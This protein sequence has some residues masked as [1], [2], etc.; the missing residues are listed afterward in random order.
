ML[1]AWL[2][3]DAIKPGYWATP[4]PLFAVATGRGGWVALRLVNDRC[5]DLGT[6]PPHP[7]FAVATGGG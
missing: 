4:H 7:L 5:L 3:T 6:E 2:P 1:F